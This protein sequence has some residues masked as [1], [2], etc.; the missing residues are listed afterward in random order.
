MK[1]NR[2]NWIR[3]SVAAVLI[4]CATAASAVDQPYWPSVVF[5]G[6]R[7]VSATSTNSGTTGLS[8]G[9]AYVCFAMPSL[10]NY[11]S[12][13]GL[14]EAHAATN[15]YIY[16][17]IYAILQRYYTEL[18]DDSPPSTD[19]GVVRT[20]VWGDSGTAAPTGIVTHAVWTKR[21]AATTE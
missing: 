10:T 14:T 6:Y 7:L 21:T 2:F 19:G 11:V 3:A 15:G 5:S 13:G 12:S 1:S 16:R 9:T 8:A 4:G 18:S 17:V 20:A